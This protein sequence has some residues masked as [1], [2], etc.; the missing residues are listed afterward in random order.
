MISV[1]LPMPQIRIATGISAI[2]GS[3][4]NRSTVDP[5]HEATVA[6]SATA[7]PTTPPTTTAITQASATQCIV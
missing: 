3:D 7:K 1:L 2:T 4:R 6:L 5:A